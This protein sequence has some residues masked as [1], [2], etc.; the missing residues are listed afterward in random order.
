METTHDRQMKAHIGGV[1]YVPK[2]ECSL[3][4][5]RAATQK[6]LVV[7]FG[8]RCCWIKNSTEKVV[9]K[10]KLVN[11]MYLLNCKTEMASVAEANQGDGG[12]IQMILWHQRLGYLN[13]TQLIQAVKKVM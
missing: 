3:F 2:L 13:K 5:I 7:Q 9:G 6:G 11:C 10:G 12:N 4:S 1:L 8:H